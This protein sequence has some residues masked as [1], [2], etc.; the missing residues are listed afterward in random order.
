MLDGSVDD[1]PELAVLKEAVQQHLAKEPPA[2][3]TSSI[4]GGHVHRRRRAR[5]GWRPGRH[6]G[7][8]QLAGAAGVVFVDQA[9]ARG[10]C[11]QRPLVEINARRPACAVSHGSPAK[12]ER[13]RA[14]VADATQCRRCRS[15]PGERL[16]PSSDSQRW[17]I[18]VLVP[19]DEII[20]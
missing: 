17:I 12:G 6:Q 20:Q 8:S 10:S 18:S 14:V 1:L 9:A 16:E 5:D 7:S 19:R 15:A 2:Q 11:H 13:L 4:A 3:M